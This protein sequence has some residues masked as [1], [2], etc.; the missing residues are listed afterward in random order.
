MLQKRINTQTPSEE[1][2]YRYSDNL[3]RLK[4]LTGWLSIFVRWIRLRPSS[5]LAIFILTG[6]V[7]IAI[8][9]PYI[10]PYNPLEIHAQDRLLRPST[11]YLLGTDELGRDMLS[12][13]MHA[14]R[15]SLLIALGAE[16][17]AVV[18]G[19]PLGLLAGYIRGPVDDLIMRILDSFLAFPGLLIG[20]TIVGLFGTD[21]LTLLI[22][23]GIMNMPYLA[24]IVRA[25]VL[26]ER[27]KDYVLATQ[28]IGA[29]ELYIMVRTILP[30]TLSPLIVQISFGLAVAILTE[31]SLSFLGL[32]VQPPQKSWG[33][34]LQIGYSYIR[35]NAWLVTIP[36]MFIFTTVW[37]LNIIGDSLRD[38]MDP[39]LRQVSGH[40]FG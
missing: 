15:I 1:S 21:K 26:V 37:S 32:G 28:A 6:M 35:I 33:T 34:L 2:G 30:N 16:A 18:I 22:A 40:L 23:I 8:L 19:V 14:A 25:A 20:I 5:V 13:L 7:F 3:K 27:V 17:V 39:R 29:H 12:M 36:G 31:A 11:M 24:R 38:A 10:S 4:I 9:A